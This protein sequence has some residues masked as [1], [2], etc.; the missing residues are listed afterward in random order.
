VLYGS[1]AGMRLSERWW[2]PVTDRR[3]R[4]IVRGGYGALVVLLALAAAEAYRIQGDIVRQSEAIHRRHIRE[5]DILYNFRRAL[6]LA[7][8][9]ARDFFLDTSASRRE[10]FQAE[11]KEWK[12]QAEAALNDLDALGAPPERRQGLRT[13][14]ADYWAA[15]EPVTQWTDQMRRERGFAFVQS[16]IVPRRNAAGEVLREWAETSGESLQAAEADFAR[17]QRSAGQR[18]LLIVGLCLGCGLAVAYAS[19][20]YSERLARE[21]RRQFQQAEES[22]L[23]LERLSARLVEIQEEERRRISRELHD[24]IGQAVTALRLEISSARA[25]SGDAAVAKRLERARDL[26]ER[27]L[28][29]VRD[30]SLLLRP[31]MLDDLG[32]GAALEW[33]AEEFTR[34][35][36]VPCTVSGGGVAGD[37]PEAAKICLYRAVQ[38]A[39]HNCERHAAASRLRIAVRREQR[40]IVLEVEDNGRGFDPPEVARRRAGLGLLGMRERAAMLGGEL[41]VESSPGRGARLRLRLPQAAAS[42]VETPRAEVRA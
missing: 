26:A 39:L 8:I 25:L 27:T 5:L 34:R 22:R 16:E 6:Y 14:I 42:R 15:L 17:S 35:T 21:R 36:G 32:L 11:L 9:G 7:S 13:R 3:H 30:I 24:E 33:L 38:E 18:L 31:A 12:Q 40:D 37:L 19:L 4:Y 41:Q 23:E 29:T 10:I 20:A 28:Q 2:R 1:G